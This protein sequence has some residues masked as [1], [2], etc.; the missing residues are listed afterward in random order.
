M[1]RKRQ[2]QARAILWLAILGVAAAAAAGE[3][4]IV[5]CSVDS[6]G[7]VS[8]GGDFELRGTIGQPDAGDLASGSFGMFGGYWFGCVPG[9][10][11]C[12]GDVDLDDYTALADCLTGPQGGPVPVDCAD[13]DLDIDS[14][15]DLLDFAEFQTL[16]T[17]T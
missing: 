7:G 17:C 2:R 11:D 5:R 12:D 14:D 10:G 15:V 3:Y 16:F 6:G 8:T 9:D 4:E 13:F 1:T